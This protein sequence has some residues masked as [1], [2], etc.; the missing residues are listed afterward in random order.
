MGAD[1]DKILRDSEKVREI[2]KWTTRYAENR[3]L[4]TLVIMVTAF[5]V[6]VVILFLFAFGMASFGKGKMLLTVALVFVFVAISIILIIFVVKYG[7]KKRG[8]IDQLI[9]QRIY[10]KEGIVSTSAAKLTKKKKCLDVFIGIVYTGCLLGS[11]YLAIIDYIPVKYILPII[12]IFYIPFQVYLY[13]M[14]RPRLVSLVLVC[15]ILYAVH[16]IL[17]V[18]G[19]PIFFTGTFAV[20]L[21]MLVPIVYMF[22][23]YLAGHFY[24]RYALRKLKAVA[25]LQEDDNE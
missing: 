15:P 6:P 4:T 5:L 18:A 8:L 22:L 24:S 20:S 21:N 1:Q 23:T 19:V 13:F 16:A 2:T 12:A 14:Q 7:G 11:M 9:N 3:T 10:G 17:I 25:H